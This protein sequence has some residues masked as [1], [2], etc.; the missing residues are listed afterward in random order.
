MGEARSA[1]T[2]S[3]VDPRRPSAARMYDYYQG[4]TDNFAC[5][6]QAADPIL[7]LVPELPSVLGASRAF[8]TA[9]VR[10]L[11][12]LGVRQFLDIGTGIPTSP[13]VHQVA[14]E[15]DPGARVVYVD[16]DPT[17]FDLTSQRTAG[18]DGVV[19]IEADL[20]DPQAVLAAPEMRLLDFH[21][22]VA[23]LLVAVLHFIPDGD[24]PAGIIEQL[25]AP[26]PPGSYLVLSSA[27]GD[28]ADPATLE[29]VS[30]IYSTATAP[31]IWRSQADVKHLLGGLELLPPGLV[32]PSVWHAPD[33][34]PATPADN[35]PGSAWAAD[36]FCAGVGV[37]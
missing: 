11:A 27:V 36:W 7:K 18:L 26:C 9:A 31:F 14:R 2:P 34:P 20:R 35:G 12:Q 22:P 13:N 4:G 33:T 19:P 8:Q 24:D 17:V 16:H 25:L 21:E 30:R 37:T 32:R 15:V 28:D 29:T 1:R 23:V 10:Y 5:D 6:R 3:G